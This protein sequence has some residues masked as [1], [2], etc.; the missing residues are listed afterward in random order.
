[1][2]TCSSCRGE[3]LT[4][5]CALCLVDKTESWLE[6]QK[7]SLLRECGEFIRAKLLKTSKN[8]SKLTCKHCRAQVEHA[9]CPL[10][11][12]DMVTG[13]LATKDTKLAMAYDQVMNSVRITV[14]D[15]YLHNVSSKV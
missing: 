2:I 14:K 8:Y 3:I 4:P 7:V 1:M 11:F 13:W 10:C 5:V 6:T 15:R 9:L 12:T